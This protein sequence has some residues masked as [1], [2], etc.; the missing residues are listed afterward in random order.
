MVAGRFRPPELRVLRLRYGFLE[1]LQRVYPAP[2]VALWNVFAEGQVAA[3]YEERR[4]TIDALRV[5]IAEG[6]KTA[7][8]RGERRL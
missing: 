2:L 4:N 7:R 6:L 1:A 5:A 8:V 3:L